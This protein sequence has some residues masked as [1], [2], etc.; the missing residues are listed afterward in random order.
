MPATPGLAAGAFGFGV[1]SF[2][3]SM[4]VHAPMPD[5]PAP[6]IEHWYL[7]HP[8]AVELG[9]L[10]MTI[11][12]IG[13]V[14]CLTEIRE[15]LTTPASTTGGAAGMHALGVCGATLFIA[16]TWAPL[17]LAVSADRGPEAP[18]AATVHL[19]SDL[20]WF[21]Y[22]SQDLVIGASTA[23]LAVLIRRQLLARPWVGWTALASALLAILGGAANFFPQSHGRLNG[24][25][26]MGFLGFLLL[27]ITMIAVGLIA[28]RDHRSPASPV[29]GLTG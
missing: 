29:S 17:L 27:D 15:G 9:E 26:I 7:T 23:C 24:F 22:A 14:W 1:L 25:T 2:A 28:W 8:R 16:G 10:L 13:F 20:A 11:A 5:Q 19:L 21:H 18:T 6:A 3:A 4:I 12:I